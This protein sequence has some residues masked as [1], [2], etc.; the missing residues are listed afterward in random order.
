MLASR[1]TVLTGLLVMLDRPAARKTVFEVWIASSVTEAV[2][3]RVEIRFISVRT[4]KE[5]RERI[6]RDVKAEPN[7]TTEVEKGTHE[8]ESKSGR[9]KLGPP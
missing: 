2:D 6:S 5:V 7:G 3:A 8:I 1:A 4:G 9:D